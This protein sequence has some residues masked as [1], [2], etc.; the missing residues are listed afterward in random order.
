[1]VT[2]TYLMWGQSALHRS[3][4]L[5]GRDLPARRGGLAIDWVSECGC[6]GIEIESVGLTAYLWHAGFH[7]LRINKCTDDNP[8]CLGQP[9][10]LSTALKA[11]ESN[12][13]DEEI[14]M[15]DV[16]VVHVAYLGVCGVPEQ[17][18]RYVRCRSLADP[19]HKQA[20]RRGKGS[21]RGCRRPF[22]IARAMGEE[23]R[24]GSD[25]VENC[26]TFYDQ[27]W[28]PSTFHRTAFTKSGV[29]AS[30]VHVVPE[31]VDFEAFDPSRVPGDFSFW[32]ADSPVT[33]TFLS[34]FK[35]E[36]RKNW[37]QLLRA[38]M[39][40]FAFRPSVGLFIKTST[41]MGADPDGESMEFMESVLEDIVRT[42]DEFGASQDQIL[43]YPH[44]VV[45]ESLE[46]A[47]VTDPADPRC[48]LNRIKTAYS[49]MPSNEMPK[50]YKAA[51]AFVLPS[52]GEG[53]GLPLMEA[54]AMELPTIGTKFGGNVDFMDPSC[55]FLLDAK[56]VRTAMGAGHWGQP[57]NEQLMTH[58]NWVVHNQNAAQE[59]GKRARR[60]LLE[61]FS[62]GSVTRIMEAKLQ[63]IGDRV[64]SGSVKTG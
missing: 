39:Y 9:E 23:D 53:W 29:E 50:L 33:V 18:E 2:L 16:V 36:D 52:H 26:N 10:R 62:P 28:V 42:T 25:D 48:I 47:W 44:E 57:S 22:M 14:E 41:Y 46:Q 17:Y 3:S 58:M 51:D 13:R 20:S 38:F 5:I 34:V 6:T 60:H 56:R 8:R 32:A 59:L 31:I 55:S 12:R 19:D 43:N 49:R 21:G 1:V 15:P 63:D 45:L 35:W 30:K 61:H 24:I 64:I 40:M 7:N 54:M 11:L 27:V 4:R 37:R